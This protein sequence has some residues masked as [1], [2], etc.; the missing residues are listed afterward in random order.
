LAAG[1]HD[2]EGRSVVGVPHAEWIYYVCVCSFT[3]T[4][5]SLEMLEEYVAYY[6]KK[7]LPSSRASAIWVGEP[8]TKFDRLPQYLRE[9]AKRQK[10]VKALTKAL[11]E[12]RRQEAASVSM[13]RTD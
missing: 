3:F 12:F 7:T 6:S 9:E 5:F 2:I 1:I 8:Q 11:N 10:V 4:F 13:S